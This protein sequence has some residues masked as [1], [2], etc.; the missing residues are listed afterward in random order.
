MN[1]Q[2]II[3]ELP[4]L[5]NGKVNTPLQQEVLL[6]MMF[7]IRSLRSGYKEEK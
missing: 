6:E 5:Y 1:A 3:K 2:A 7:S 4:F